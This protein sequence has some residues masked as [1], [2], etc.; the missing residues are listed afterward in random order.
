MCCTCVDII[1]L[2]ESMYDNHANEDVCDFKRG[3]CHKPVTASYLFADFFITMIFVL[4]FWKYPSCN[5]NAQ[6]LHG[7]CETDSVVQ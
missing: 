7:Q 1:K 4:S 6:E 3:V 2:T 5:L